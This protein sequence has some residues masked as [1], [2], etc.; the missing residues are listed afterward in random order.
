MSPAAEVSLVVQRELRK[1]VRSAKGVVLLG[2]SL[3][4]GVI[5]ALVLAFVAAQEHEMIAEK[6]SS[7]P[8]EAAA[9]LTTKL[10]RELILQLGD[11][12]EAL[13]DVLV[14][15]PSPSS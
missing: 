4:G 3:L 15:P 1:N 7:L 10:Q 6:L 12:D 11:G 2:L 5:V 8:P 9:E 14:R 13:G